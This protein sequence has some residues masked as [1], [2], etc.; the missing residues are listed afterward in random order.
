MKAEIIDDIKVK[1]KEIITELL[2]EIDVDEFNENTQFLEIGFNSIYFIKLI[3]KIEN[4]FKIK[5]NKEHLS[6][7]SFD[8]YK[9]MCDVVYQLVWVKFSKNEESKREMVY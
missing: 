7:A 8:N 4:E 6:F 2:H 5:F 1:V 9:D 3:L